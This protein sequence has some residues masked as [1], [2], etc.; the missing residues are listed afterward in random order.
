M[1]CSNCGANMPDNSQFCNKCG[2]QLTSPEASFAPETVTDQANTTVKNS[3]PEGNK[4]LDILKTIGMWLSK[5]VRITPNDVGFVL[6]TLAAL[7]IMANIS[8]SADVGWIV[9]VAVLAAGCIFASL[10][11]TV[12]VSDNRYFHQNH[13][14]NGIEGAKMMSAKV[15]RQSGLAPCEECIGFSIKSLAASV[16]KFFCVIFAVSLIVTSIYNKQYPGATLF[17]SLLLSFMSMLIIGLVY[18]TLKNGYEKVWIQKGNM[19]YH[20]SK[21][22]SNMKAARRIGVMKAKS[23]GYAPC[24]K[25]S[26][27]K[28]TV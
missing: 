13:K 21:D 15:A 14:C 9:I 28:K 16:I 24:S 12:Y 8:L 17:I 3:K 25:C 11:R 10:P 1:T 27:P 7:L 19:K 2:Q 5:N 22:C 6:I 20:K 18:D 26:K 23:F 4:I